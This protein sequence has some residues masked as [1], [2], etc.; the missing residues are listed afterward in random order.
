MATL[1]NTLSQDIDILAHTFVSVYN[2]P[3]LE[4]FIGA[5]GYLRKIDCTEN[6]DID[7]PMS[8][9]WRSKLI[10]PAESFGKEYD[11]WW[12]QV[13]MVRL[14]YEDIDS[15]TPVT[16]HVSKDGG[17]NWIWQHREIGTG[18]DKEKS[19]D[20]HFLSKDLVGQFFVFK[21]ECVSTTKDFRW[22]GLE[23]DFI[24][25]GPYFEI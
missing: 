11:G 20:Y 8:C 19:A 23:V 16:I 2:A 24:P 10:D 13:D 21:I 5:Y 1:T 12:F 15:S 18:N 4:T 25:R 17:V 9:Y 7:K 3:V 14:L 22:I 6:N